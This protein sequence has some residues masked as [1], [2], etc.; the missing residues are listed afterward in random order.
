MNAI[1]RFGSAMIVPVILFAFFGIVVGLATLFKNENIMGSIAAKGTTWFNIWSVVESGGWTI[2]THMELAFVIG[3]PISL[4]KKAQGRA[5]LAALMIYLV[6]NNF[7]NALLTIWPDV[8]GVDLSKGVENVTGVKTIAGI[9]TLDTSIIGAILISAIAIWIHNRFYD[10]KLPEMLGIFQGLTFVVMIGF[11]LM[12]PVA[13]VTAFVWPYVQ[14]GIK[15][16]QGVMLHSG[17]I[18]VW[19]FHFL[20]RIL[21]PTGLHHFIYTPF[22]FGPTAVDGGLRPYWIHHL[23]EFSNS[24]KALK[25][26]YPYGFLLQGNIKMFGL[27]GVAL[28]MVFSTPKANRK[29]VI[30][31]VVPA[32]LT[33]IFAGITEPLEFTFLFIAPYLF[34]IHAVLGATMVTLMNAFGVVGLMGGGLI[35]IAATNW[36]PLFGNHASVYI[37]QF[38]IGFIFTGIY[39]VTFKYLIEKFD[40]PIPGRKGDEGAKLFTKKDY[41]QKQSASKQALVENEYDQKAIYYF[42]GLG[43]KDNIVDV[44][45]CAT[46]LRL[47]VKDPNLVR[48]SDYF[49]HEQMAHGLVKSGRSIQVIVG[50]SVPQVRDYF[51]EKLEKEE[52]V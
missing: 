20:E 28:A 50:M 3:L 31:L 6:F 4:A 24:T 43:G 45:N 17:L 7:I 8:F 21:I 29:K 51:E 13:I 5:T 39:F 10:Q 33:A 27:L 40:I 34:A 48:E 30:A 19:L 9:P 35:E 37:A 36:I 1:K 52:E 49:T 23:N 2:F 12:I 22:E 26:L 46:R 41:Q 32:S 18:G 15:S 14:V 38:I 44:T 42:E 25:E 47:T 11:F 16:L